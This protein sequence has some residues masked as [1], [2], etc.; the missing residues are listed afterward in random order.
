MFYAEIMQDS[1]DHEAIK[2][3][4]DPRFELYR[5][6]FVRPLAGIFPNANR[7]QRR[8]VLDL[9]SE[10]SIQ[11]IKIEDSAER[12]EL[13]GL[14]SKKAI[15]NALNGAIRTQERRI[16][17]GG[18]TQTLSVLFVD[19]DGVKAI[20]DTQGHATGDLAIADIAEAIKTSATRP[21][22]STGRAG[23]GDEF[24]IVLPETN[25]IGSLSIAEEIRQKVES[26]QKF[27]GFSVSIGIAIYSGGI[28]AAEF[29]SK[30]DNAMYSAKERRNAIAIHPKDL[31]DDPTELAKITSFITEKGIRVALPNKEAV[32]QAAFLNRA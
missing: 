25:L 12:D 30:A 21:T 23:L 2:I 24:L 29:I 7:E 22:D 6:E 18:L 8:Q 3:Q 14:L 9:A 15:E 4:E 13:T 10:W 16:F 27:P 26:N 20:N 32:N 31:P 5:D 11:K 1:P 17:P 19:G 28:T